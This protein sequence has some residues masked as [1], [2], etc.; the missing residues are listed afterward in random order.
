MILWFCC[1][2]AAALDNGLIRKTN[3]MS[4][5]DDNVLNRRLGQTNVPFL[6]SI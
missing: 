2:I 1:S 6:Y 3:A 5:P 4:A